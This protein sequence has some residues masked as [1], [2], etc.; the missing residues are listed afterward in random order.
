MQMCAIALIDTYFYKAGEHT[1]GLAKD[2][3]IHT[4]THTNTH[5]HTHN[6]IVEKASAK[7]SS[8]GLAIT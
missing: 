2:T 1:S 3:D 7:A 5:T 8:P 4:H 6:H